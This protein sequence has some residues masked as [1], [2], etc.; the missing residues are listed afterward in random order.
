MIS[1]GIIGA[2]EEEIEFIKQKSD[3]AETIKLAGM[4]FYRC[5]FEGVEFIA[6]VSGIGKV[7]AAICTQMLIDNFHPRFIINTGVAGAA[8]EIL[9]IGDIVISKDLVEYD[10][11]ASAFG[12]PV[13]QVPRMD[14]YGFNA[15]DK[16]ISVA[17]KSVEKLTAGKNV[18]IGRIVSGD[19]FVS[20]E[21]DIAR[22]RENFNAFAVEMEGAAI[23][24]TCYINR[25]P[26][27][28]IRTISD[29]ADGKADIDFS[30]FSHESSIVSSK[31]SLD[32][33]CNLK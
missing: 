3:V 26:F 18:I 8:S 21:G 12:D 10:M 13:G 15:D 5:F 30:K 4:N 29:R 9:N 22:I 17:K 20:D 27:V 2:M 1:A 14:V 32:I 28:V 31:I 23:G 6:V 25:V 24:H 11:D 7:N 16:L 33:V 19:R